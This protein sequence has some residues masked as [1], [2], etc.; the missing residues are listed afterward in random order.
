MTYSHIEVNKVYIVDNQ[1]FKGQHEGQQILTEVYMID[2][3][4][5]KGQH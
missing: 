1:L 2:S 5:L 3:Q 4:G